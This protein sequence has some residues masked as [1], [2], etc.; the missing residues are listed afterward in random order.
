MVQLNESLSMFSAYKHHAIDT[1]KFYTIRFLSQGVDN[2]NGWRSENNSY[3]V[4]ESSTYFISLNMAVCPSSYLMDTQVVILV[5]DKIVS[6]MYKDNGG[7]L[8]S[9]LLSKSILLNL[10]LNGQVQFASKGCLKF[11]ENEGVVSMF[12]IN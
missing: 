5:N 7:H 4:Q 9:D 8:G 11:D 1:S 2:R 3:I 6:G 10:Q 12:A